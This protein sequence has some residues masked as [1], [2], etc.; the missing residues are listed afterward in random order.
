MTSCV[1]TSQMQII[2]KKMFKIMK[3]DVNTTD[4]SQFKCDELFVVE[5]L[6]EYDRIIVNGNDTT[7]LNNSVGVMRGFMPQKLVGGEISD[8]I[9]WLIEEKDKT[10]KKISHK[11]TIQFLE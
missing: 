4:T 10:I 9:Y 7:I 11:F 2:L 1:I 5:T 6:K 3:T 8:D